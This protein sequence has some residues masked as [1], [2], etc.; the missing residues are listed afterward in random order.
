MG[1]FSRMSEVAKRCKN[2]TT[3]VENR[4]SL[5]DWNYFSVEGWGQ[6]ATAATSWG[7]MVMPRSKITYP[8][9]VLEDWWKTHF[10]SLQNSP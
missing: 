8:R 9:K 1:F 4:K 7:S 2:L 10:S 5:M 6:L 3:V